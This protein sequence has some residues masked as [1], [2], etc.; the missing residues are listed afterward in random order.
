MKNIWIFTFLLLLISPQKSF[1]NFEIE[2]VA[3]NPDGSP[4]VGTASI[5]VRLHKDGDP[6][7]NLYIET[8]SAVVMDQEGE[9]SIT[10]GTGSRTGDFVSMNPEVKLSNNV[11]HFCYDTTGVQLS[12]YIPASGDVRS[13]SVTV[14]PT[15]GGTNF[16]LG[17]MRLNA[18]PY[19]RYAK[20]AKAVGTHSISTLLRVEDSANVPTT[21]TVAALTPTN[22][23]DL[24][25]LLNGTSTKYVNKTS[26]SGVVFPS[27]APTSPTAGS[28]WYSSGSIQ[29]YDGTSTQTLTGGGGTGV[30]NSGNLNSST[31]LNLNAGG[32][33]QNVNILPTGT[34]KVGIGTTSPYALLTVGN[35]A[36]SNNVI[37]TFEG[38]V[39]VRNNS[40][41]YPTT[42]VVQ[43]INGT[44]NSGAGLEFKGIANSTAIP[45]GRVAGYLTDQTASNEKGALLFETNHNGAVTEKMRITSDGN[46]GIGTT[47]PLDKLAVT[48]KIRATHICASDGTNCKDLTT[49]WNPGTVTAVTAAGLPL[50]VTS[51]TTSPVISIAQATTSTDGY[52]SAADWNSFSSKVGTNLTNANIW[53]GNVSNVAT[54]QPVTGDISLSNAGVTAVTKLRGNPVDSTTLM[55]GDSGKIYKWSGSSLIAGYF[56]IADLKKSDGTAQFSASCAAHQTLTWSAVTDSFTCSNISG[57]P[58]SAISSGVIATAQLGSG[59]PTGSN[60]LRGDGT[61]ATPSGDNFGNHIASMNIQLGNNWLSGDGGNEGIKIDAN[62]NVGIG[63]S[64]N[65]SYKLD[66]GGVGT[67]SQFR[68]NGYRIND[69]NVNVALLNENSGATLFYNRVGTTNSNPSFIFSTT[70]SNSNALHILNNGNVGIGFGSPTDKLEV[71]GNIYTPNQ[72]SFGQVKSD[73]GTAGAP[74][75]TFNNSTTYGIL[76]P[77]I[78]VLAFSTSS[79]ERMRILSSGN[80]GVG[81]TNPSAKLHVNGDI[82]ASNIKVTGVYGNSVP[83]VFG[84]NSTEYMRIDSV[85]NVGIGTAAPT[86]ILDVQRAAASGNGAGIKLKAQDSNGANGNG[87]NIELSAGAPNGTGIPGMIKVFS[88]VVLSNGTGSLTTSGGACIA[89]TP[90][91]EYNGLNFVDISYNSTST[92]NSIECARPGINGQVLHLK[93][94]NT[95]TGMNAIKIGNF[96]QTC[97]SGYFPIK[98]GFD[99]GLPTINGRNGGGTSYSKLVQMIYH[100]NTWWI[101]TN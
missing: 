101:V 35:T 53:V 87:G 74:G 7:C 78:D 26:T 71:N 83:L 54:A 5:A 52:L 85:G 30:T 37:A 15:A 68:I 10:I 32:T 12:P 1:A 72:G 67:S 92:V 49:T 27:G 98:T 81:I 36:G 99:T 59:T 13:V 46:V 65:A 21:S 97:D 90:C 44:P 42:L 84:Y 61:W 80:V 94:T 82:W 89:A 95:N 16:E 19:A 66:I 93:V 48:G 41:G 73:G 62:G 38:I 76:A 55:A 17:P 28:I 57:L 50:T 25:A 22:F 64:P 8:H 14:T 79:T 18:V 6:T 91:L 60:F 34:G 69:D 47:A 23:S 88:P 4:M 20:E 40:P 31:V 100:S 58:A 9:F 43:N 3:Q 39:A 51:G 70:T 56:S 86:A 29:Y 24:V 77:A 33:N 96:D 45:S 63:T 2:G 11:S 75:Y